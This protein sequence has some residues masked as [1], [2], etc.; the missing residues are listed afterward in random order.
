[1]TESQSETVFDDLLHE[2]RHFPPPQAFADQ[3]TANDPDLFQK[4]AEDPEGYWE[5]EARQLEWFEPWS[6]VLE[7]TPPHCKWFLGGKLNITHN[8]L[9]RHLEQ[10]GDKAALI[11]EGEPGDQKTLTFAEVH[12][13][14]CRFANALKSLGIGKGDRVAI[15]MP[16]VP[17]AAIAMLACARI[18]AIHSVVFGGFSAESLSDRI[19]DSDCRALITADGGYR[20]GKILPLKQTADKA[21]ENTSTIEHVVVVRRDEKTAA[22][23]SMAEGRDHWYHDLVAEASD[24]CPAEPMDAEDVLFI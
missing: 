14:T 20:R 21:L 16:M 5:Q 23:C 17:E 8:C 19:N 13:E 12:A 11:W 2:L 24:D 18:G 22:S 4:A 1:M 10:N 6:K 3:A 15:Y 7:W 9:D